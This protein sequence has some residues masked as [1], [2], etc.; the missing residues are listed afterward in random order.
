MATIEL[1]NTSDKVEVKPGDVQWNPAAY[2]CHVAIIKECD[3]SFSAIVIN[4]PGVG[5]CGDTEEDVIANVRE[6]V[7]GAVES[8][9]TSGDPIPWLDPCADD[10]HANIPEGAKH[11]WMVVHG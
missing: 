6:A 3:E 2:R 4:L 1:V 5:S 11:F 10:Y 7:L 8:F 9:K